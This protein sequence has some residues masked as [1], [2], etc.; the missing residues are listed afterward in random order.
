MLSIWSLLAAVVE[1]VKT[2]QQVLEV[3]VVVRVRVVQE[4][5]LAAIL[6]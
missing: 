1:V 6:L 5:T 2:L 4:Q 3:E